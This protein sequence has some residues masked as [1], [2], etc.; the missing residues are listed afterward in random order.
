MIYRLEAIAMFL[1]GQTI[2]DVTFVADL[3]PI[4]ID[5]RC[6]PLPR[7]VP[8]LFFSRSGGFIYRHRS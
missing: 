4:K 8:G 3:L 2:G 6:I 7:L 1:V 5:I